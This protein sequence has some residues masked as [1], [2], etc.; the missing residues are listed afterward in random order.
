M[1][2]T[3]GH[4]GTAWCV[5]PPWP[6]SAT[7][8]ASVSHEP[9]RSANSMAHSPITCTLDCTLHLRRSPAPAPTRACALAPLHLHVSRKWYL[10]CA[11]TSA[12][13]YGCPDPF[14]CNCTCSCTRTCAPAITA[15]PHLLPPHLRSHMHPRQHMHLRSH[16]HTCTCTYVRTRQHAPGPI[17]AVFGF[18]TI[19][20]QQT[21]FLPL[22]CI[23]V[24]QGF[25][26]SKMISCRSS[27]NKPNLLNS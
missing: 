1:K 8:P 17:V 2:L 22:N 14:T 23:E 4:W 24:L 20:N 9:V 21:Q 3:D 5:G 26:L 16:T 18:T 15:P 13:L 11:C 19:Q 10:H 25:W 27:N 12:C 6:P 7:A